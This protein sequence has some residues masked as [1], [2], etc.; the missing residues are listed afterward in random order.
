MFLRIKGKK[1]LEIAI[2]RRASHHGL[3]YQINIMKIIH[4][5]VAA[6]MNHPENDIPEIT[7]ELIK[8]REELE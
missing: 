6:K 1:W 2:Y 5:A 3:V 7:R 4:G 8:F